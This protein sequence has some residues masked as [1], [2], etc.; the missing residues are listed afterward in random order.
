M[1]VTILFAFYRV[2]NSDGV[3][4]AKE[5]CVITAEGCL[6]GARSIRLMFVQEISQ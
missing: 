6:R 2:L 1:L 5:T 4:L 3:M